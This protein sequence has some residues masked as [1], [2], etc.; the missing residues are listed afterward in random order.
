[1]YVQPFKCGPDYLDPTHHTRAARR[2]SFNLDLFMM[3]EAHLRDVFSRRGGHAD[4]A[5]VEGMMGLFDG[6]DKDTASS[7]AIARL[8]QIPV[9]L[10]VDASAMAYSAAALISG[11]A[12]FR[13]EVR[14]VGVI[15][16]F[17]NSLGHFELLKQACADVGVE[18]V[19]YVPRSDALR[20]P[21]RHLGLAI[22]PENDY[23]SVI[24]RAAEHVRKTVNVER[25]L[26][27]TR[28]V[29]VAPA[30]E[31]RPEGSAAHR[32][33]IAVARDDAFNFTYQENLH[34]LQR[35][36]E[37]EFFSPMR[38][39]ALPAADLLY[40]AGGYP[41]LFVDALAANA[42]MHAAIRAHAASGRRILAECGGLMYLA[43]ELV[44]AKGRA[45]PM[46]GLL[47]VQTSMQSAALTIGYRTV[48]IEGRV[49][50][51]HEFHFSRSTEFEPLESAGRVADARGRNVPTKIYRH[52][53]VL[54]SYVHFYWA[55]QDALPV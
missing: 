10:V 51:G 22:S 53:G 55:E 50:R 35:F 21:S 31:S 39:R 52:G 14:V 16:N 42:A 34:A 8:L 49:W 18:A 28:S 32:L 9:I 43:R 26:E 3:S 38:D 41:E 36:G 2:P 12:R 4:V 1:L 24:A 37:V 20:L 5:V 15:F 23:E 7:A 54:A 47:P 46:V 11:Y 30:V 27:V 17:V 33:R 45:H 29:G 25:L 40:F 48:E 44:D 19:G 6:S 13:P